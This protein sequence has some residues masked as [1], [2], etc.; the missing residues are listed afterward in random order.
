MS[1]LKKNYIYN[2]M[3]NISNI[4]ISI[5]MM[6][7]LTRKLG[8][9]QIGIYSYTYSIV[10][11]FMLFS[12]LGIQNYGNRLIASISDEAEKSK[13][14]LSLYFFQVSISLVVVIFYM[15]YISLICE[16]SYQIVSIF[17]IIHLLSVAFDITWFFYGNENFKPP[18][19]FSSITKFIYLILVLFFIHDSGDLLFYTVISGLYSLINNVFLLLFSK[20]S[21]L[22][23]KI[24]FND[25]I[26]HFKP[27]LIL[28]IPV[29]SV[30]LY[31]I[32]D[33]IM[34][35]QMSN[36][37]EVGLYEYAEKI[38]KIPLQ[39]SSSLGTIMLPK[40]SNVFSKTNDDTKNNAN[41]YIL[42]SLNF[43]MGILMP[44]IFGL[45]CISDDFI[46]LFLGDDFIGTSILLKGLLIS[47]IFVA[48]G[49]V[50]RTH[51]IIPK[52]KDRVLIISVIFGAIF[53][54]IC[55]SFLIPLYAA[56]GAVIATILAEFVVVL[57]QSV[58]LKKFI[59]IKKCI[60]II[61]KYLIKSLV[62]YLFVFLVGTFNYNSVYVKVIIQV[63]I[64]ITIYLILN[65][66]Y[67]ISFFPPKFS[68]AI[69]KIIK[70]LFNKYRCRRL[71]AFYVELLYNINTND[72]I[73][74]NNPTTFSEKITWIKA[75]YYD[76]RYEL[77]SDKLNVREYV[78]SKGLESI[79]TE[80]YAVYNSVSDIKFEDLPSKFVIKCTHGSGGVCI[81]CDKKKVN[82]PK[83]LKILKY[84]MKKNLYTEYGEWQYKN[85]K[86]RIMVEELIEPNFN[87]LLIDYKMFCFNGKV[88][89]I[90]PMIGISTL[91]ESY[92]D[93]YD[94]EWHYIDIKCSSHPQYGKIPKPQKLKDL[95]RVAEI[96]SKDF[97]HVRVD[98]YCV[99]NRIYFGELTFTTS[100]GISIFK[101][102]DDDILF[103]KL[104][105]LEKLKCPEDRK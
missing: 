93:F 61:C 18:L 33:K 43:I 85:L 10:S 15:M 69:I 74:L 38:T 73:D 17:Q 4:L 12:M 41:R 48:Y 89:Y 7:F 70:K 28:F 34:L 76:K 64:G 13:E 22:N 56:K 35:G 78:K 65:L 37:I 45:I 96:L 46:P 53:N 103:G 63:I 25:I 105:D 86:P 67:L 104:F 54:I 83:I 3:L 39:L 91:N 90:N 11:F 30:S 52:K 77:C 58:Y 71:N 100:A 82:I 81:V 59:D 19:I 102:K 98:L 101:Y 29:I 24:T 44:A 2:L 50:I 49:C 84:N 42:N 51:Y 32:V 5:I 80:V 92:S 68:K 36:V 75:N 94:A 31:K 87:N 72:K 62:M 1:K 55:N 79:L 99:K 88:K 6:P 57:Y 40:M 66:N 14:F 47:I 21:I 8:G 97:V 23:S 9:E 20:K 95:I 60:K 16:K 27:C 26:K